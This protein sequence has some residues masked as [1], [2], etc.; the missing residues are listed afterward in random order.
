MA[1]SYN[2]SA[3]VPGG[4]SFAVANAIQTAGRRKPPAAPSAPAVGSPGWLMSAPSQAVAAW[5]TTLHPDYSGVKPVDPAAA[6]SYAQQQTDAYMKPYLDQRATEQARLDEQRRLSLDAGTNFY[7]ALADVI[8]G[9]QSGEAGQ[10]YA[11][12]T[13]GGSFLAELQTVEGQKMFQNVTRDFNAQD[14]AL[15]DRYAQ[16][17]DKRP[18]IYQQLYSD[19]VSQEQANQKA[20]ISLADSNYEHRMKAAALILTNT[21][22]R[23]ANLAKA[24][25]GSGSQYTYR[26]LA[27]GQLAVIDNAT[28]K[29]VGTIGDARATKPTKRSTS[30]QTVNG[31]RVLVDDQ[32]GQVIK[33]AGK[34]GTGGT[35]DKTKVVASNRKDAISLGRSLWTQ[36]GGHPDVNSAAA[37]LWASYGQA[38][39]DAGVAPASAARAIQQALRTASGGVW[40]WDPTTPLALRIISGT[41]TPPY[42]SSTVGTATSGNPFTGG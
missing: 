42:H 36:K 1:T 35:A 30:W 14:Q 15:A 12:K 17:L 41:Y 33:T 40:R 23:E 21:Q 22:K 8:T 9:G 26:T 19:F 25:G 3:Y 39:V 34:A 11:L 20:G 32:T 10:Q 5:M 28:G 29:Q 37:A 18:D 6:A 16:I 7:K 13:F 38:M 31:Q 2:P 27:N 24:L 4:S